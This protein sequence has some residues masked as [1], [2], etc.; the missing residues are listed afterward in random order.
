MKTIS[1][2]C[3]GAAPLAH[4]NGFP[5]EFPFKF[6]ACYF[7]L[8]CSIAAPYIMAHRIIALVILCAIFKDTWSTA[9]LSE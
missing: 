5:F 7:S 8:K 2:K 4:C 6:F 9:A 3:I 1:L